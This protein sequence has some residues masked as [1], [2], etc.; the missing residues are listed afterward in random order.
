M[1]ILNKFHLIL[2]QTHFKYFSLFSFKQKSFQRKSCFDFSSYNTFVIRVRGD[3]RAYAIILQAEG[4]YDVM[5]HDSFH[6]VL[7]TRGGPHWQLSKV[8]LN[9]SIEYSRQIT[10][11]FFFD[12]NFRSH[13]QSFI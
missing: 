4:V 2:S 7:Y 5:W 10:N 1:V 12:C 9:N 6:Y 11:C 13:S 3:G 8:N